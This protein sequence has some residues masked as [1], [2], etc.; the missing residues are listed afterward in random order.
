MEKSILLE[1]DEVY[2]RIKLYE[3]EFVQV[4]WF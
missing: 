3:K 2:L 4:P 1:R